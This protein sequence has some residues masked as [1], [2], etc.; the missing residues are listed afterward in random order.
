[1]KVLITGS[2]GFVGR[3][4]TEFLSKKNIFI[5]ALINKTKVKKKKKCFLYKKQY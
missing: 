3:H 1:M 2:G 5:Y 4:L